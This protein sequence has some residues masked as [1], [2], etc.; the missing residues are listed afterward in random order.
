MEQHRRIGQ[1]LFDKIGDIERVR[2]ILMRQSLDGIYIANNPSTYVH[3][4][5]I[6]ENTIEDLLTVRAGRLVRWKGANKPE[7]RQA[8]FDPSA[9]SRE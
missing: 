7:E 9:G 3:E 1:S 5:S 6:G 8:R 2:T 4:D